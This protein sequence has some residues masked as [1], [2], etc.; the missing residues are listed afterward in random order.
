MNR[1]FTKQQMA[2]INKH[3]NTDSTLFRKYQGFIF[4]LLNQ[5]IHHLNVDIQ[6]WHM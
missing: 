1:L 5:K 6:F 2:I 3:I 4:Q